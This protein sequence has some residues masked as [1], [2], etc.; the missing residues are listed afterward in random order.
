MVKVEVIKD[1]S[2]ESIL[3]LTLK[4]VRRGSIVY[5]DR[6]KSYDS[7]MLC[8]YRHLRVDHAKRFAQGKVYINGLEGFWAYAK[9]KPIDFNGV[10]KYYFPLYL[11][12]REFGYKHRKQLI[13]GL[14]VQYP[15]DFVAKPL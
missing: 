5:T 7:L 2:A 1:V 6:F 4:K 3:D 8:G 10:S 15:S 11:K 9:E 12:E 14:L 13:F